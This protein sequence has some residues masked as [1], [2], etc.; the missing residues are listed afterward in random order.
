MKGT[1][2]LEEAYRFLQFAS[3][4]DRQADQTNYISYGPANKDAI[5]NVNKDI[6]VHLPTNPENMKTVLIVQPQFWADNGDALRERF[7]AWVAQ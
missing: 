4:P 2:K 7:N 5:P 6:L 1:P 3:R